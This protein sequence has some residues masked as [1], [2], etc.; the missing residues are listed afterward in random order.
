MVIFMKWFLYLLLF[1]LSYVGF[2]YFDFTQISLITV[3][4]FLFIALILQ[5]I[6]HEL[7][8]L[9][10]GLTTGYTFISFRIF[11]FLIFKKNNRIRVMILPDN[12][13]W[14]Q[15]L[16]APPNKNSN[17][18]FPY[19]WYSLGG[20]FF[21]FLFACFLVPFLFTTSRHT[22]FW[23]FAL[24]ITGLLL[25]LFNAIPSLD[26]IPND[27]HNLRAMKRNAYAKEAYYI[28]L[29]ANAHVFT[30]QGYASLPRE[31]FTLPFSIP[32]DE[33]LVVTA[34]FI[35]YYHYI[36]NLEFETANTIIT[37]LDQA[38]DVLKYHHDLIVLE[39]IFSLL[40]S[41][42]LGQA[43]TRLDSLSPNL[44]QAFLKSSD[45]DKKRILYT[46]N[47]LL[48][49]NKESADYLYQQCLDAAKKYHLVGVAQDE[50]SLVEAIRNRIMQE[51]TE[52]Q[53]NK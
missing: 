20:V 51:N 41:G 42:Y 26:K 6:L 21:N 33:P 32:I 30:D 14:G 11:I 29:V 9:V 24:I 37:Q 4:F 38:R 53:E 27:G 8:H 28:Q 1:A 15:C 5:V 39:R 35:E 23:V 12:A 44:R 52:N 25:A 45:I 36:Y 19:V 49:P 13:F 48:N 22:Q 3:L 16:M 10:M 40:I 47:A 50:L 17:G 18:D 34:R 2:R 46:I 31:I 43:Q 7:G